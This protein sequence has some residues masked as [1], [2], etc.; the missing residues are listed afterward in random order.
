VTQESW[1]EVK[2]I[3]QLYRMIDAAIAQ[4]SASVAPV[5]DRKRQS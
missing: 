4:T 5:D 1:T 3:N 2:D